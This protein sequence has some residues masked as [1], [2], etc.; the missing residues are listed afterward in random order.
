[1]ALDTRVLAAFAAATPSL[2]ESRALLNRIDRKFLVRDDTLV[3]VLRRLPEAYARIETGTLDGAVYET[4][5]FD[6]P[7]LRCFH[8]HR[9]GRLPRCKVRL[10]TDHARGLT[11]LEVKR[12]GSDERTSKMRRP[13]RRDLS[14]DAR[15][16]DAAD[17]AFLAACGAP[18]PDQLR[19]ALRVRFQRVTLVGLGTEERITIDR[20]IHFTRDG[21]DALLGP[22][23]II[24][25]KQARFANVTPA[26]LALRASR[27]REINISKY[28]LGTARLSPVPAGRFTADLR[29][30]ERL[31]A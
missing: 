13:W 27:A 23:A 11:F 31:T 24:E 15:G 29:L 21:G 16:L 19:A 28:I 7:D 12:K 14:G 20:G 3:D 17:R 22:L 26:V 6:T 2:V 18:T 9:R 4:T 1:M 30:V 10:R 8:D 5:Y 25:V